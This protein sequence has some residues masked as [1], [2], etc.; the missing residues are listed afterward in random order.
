MKNLSAWTPTGTGPYPPYVSI[1]FKDFLVEITC[2]SPATSDGRDGAT[3]V[4]SMPM[5]EFKT[6]VTEAIRTHW[7]EILKQDDEVGLAW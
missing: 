3:A 4:V 7:H 2:R 1:N 6:L 5:C